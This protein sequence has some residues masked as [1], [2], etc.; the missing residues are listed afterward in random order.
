MCMWSNAA[1]L[2]A[3]QAADSSIAVEFR[4]TGEAA[5][6]EGLIRPIGGAPTCL[7]EGREGY[8]A[9]RGAD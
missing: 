9:E 8:L 5:S 2:D 7:S 6:A 4:V 3:C 1:G